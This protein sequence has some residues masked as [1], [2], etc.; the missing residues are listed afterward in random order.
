M[1]CAVAGSSAAQWSSLD[2]PDGET[3]P[4]LNPPGDTRLG[5]TCIEAIEGIL[6]GGKVTLKGLVVGLGGSDVMLE[7]L[8]GE[9]ALIEGWQRNVRQM[10]D[11]VRGRFGD[12]VGVVMLETPPPPGTNRSLT[13]AWQALADQQRQFLTYRFGRVNGD[14]LETWDDG[15][16]FPRLTSNAQA[17]LG[18]RL[19][20][21]FIDP[22]QPTLGETGS[23]SPQT[24]CFPGS[25]YRIEPAL[26][27]SGN[28]FRGDRET[29]RI[30]CD[31]HGNSLHALAAA[32]GGCI[33]LRAI[34]AELGVGIVTASSAPDLLPTFYMPQSLDGQA[35]SPLPWDD[36]YTPGPV[37][38]CGWQDQE[39]ST[40]VAEP[41]R[42]RYRVD[43]LFAEN[44]READRS[45]CGL[46]LSPQTAVRDSVTTHF[47][48][49]AGGCR[50]IVVGHGG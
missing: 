6:R 36:P 28:F 43:A 5:A 23:C 40:F 21:A 35:L 32:C 37:D 22:A 29:G 3:A 38:R 39:S 15:A 47:N 41:G 4:Y 12:Q 2:A 49:A 45:G 18:Q 24:P 19:A 10:I 44:C 25:A 20:A 50:R 31:Q 16:A 14:E 48:V 33:D 26:C 9:T 46:L 8:Q 34:A 30:L 17:Q 13:T 11:L 7:T 1:N 42:H 27:E